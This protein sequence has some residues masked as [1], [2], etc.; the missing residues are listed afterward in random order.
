MN[1]FRKVR[2]NHIWA[3]CF[4]FHVHLHVESQATADLDIQMQEQSSRGGE[5]LLAPVAVP[6]PFQLGHPAAFKAAAAGH[7]AQLVPLQL[8]SCTGCEVAVGAGKRQ[9]SFLASQV[10]VQVMLER[11]QVIGLVAASVAQE[12]ARPIPAPGVRFVLLLVPGRLCRLRRISH[13]S[14]WCL[15]NSQHDTCSPA[16]G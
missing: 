16:M 13:S 2:S 4:A 3:G 7:P 1:H 6:F 15:R 11:S 10:G 5:G 14:P 8:P 12:E 9:L